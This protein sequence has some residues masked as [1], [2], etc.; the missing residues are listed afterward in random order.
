M[1]A[2]KQTLAEQVSETLKRRIFAGTYPPGTKLPPELA[3]ASELAVNRF[4]VREAMNHLVELRLIQRRAG[5]GT[6]VLDY[7]E[8]ASVDVLE[9]LVL[10]DDGTANTRI[11]GNCLEFARIVSSEVAALAATRRS[12]VDLTEL[13]R[14]VAHMKSESS[15]SR[16]FWLDFDF[17][18]ALAG[19]AD[20][21]MPR[22][23]LNSVRGLLEKYTHLLETLWVSPG[24]IT[25]GY[26]YVVEA[27]R[28]GDAERARS[29]VLWIW[30]GRHQRFVEAAARH[31]R[32]ISRANSG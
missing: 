23:V 20:N 25:E 28:A 31:A 18:W 30:T 1:P 26:E 11:L 14:V 6:I 3:L 17:N 9:Y 2:A 24:S 16:L 19:A 8:H 15:L 32:P 22:L 13:D 7:S 12:G 29:L 4:T 5:V 10:A 27:V 21:I